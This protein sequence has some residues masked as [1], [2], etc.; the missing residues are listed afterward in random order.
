M[1]SD[2]R[3]AARQLTK[4]PGFTAVA[5]LTL[6][7]G[8]GSATVVFSAVNA[9]LLK[10]LPLVGHAED[11][12]VSLSQTHLASGQLYKGWNYPDYADLRARLTSAEGL[13]IY[14]DLTV[15]IT[16]LRRVA[17]KPAASATK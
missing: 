11:R 1:L 16:A 13:W 10:P 7:L 4:S 3:F 5:L 9:L 17:S 8:L 14:A 15:I 6:A 2:L 12:L